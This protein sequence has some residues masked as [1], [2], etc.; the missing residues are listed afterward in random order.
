MPATSSVVKKFFCEKT[1][2]REIEREIDILI[3]LQSKQYI[4]TCRNRQTNKYTNKAA[5]AIVVGVVVVVVVVFAGVLRKGSRFAAYGGPAQGL[6]ALH[7][8][9]KE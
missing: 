2:E 1:R 3:N 4:I 7:G 6:Q 5:A 9:G 8:K